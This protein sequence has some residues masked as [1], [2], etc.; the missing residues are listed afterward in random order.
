MFHSARLKLTGWYLLIIMLVSVFFSLLLFQ[1][2][3]TELDRGFR[4]AE[5]RLY[6]EEMGMHLP[7][8]FSMKRDDLQPD[9]QNLTPKFLLIED[10]KE[11]RQSILIRLFL[12]NGVILVVSAIASYAMAGK[13]L[14]PLEKALEDQKRFVADASH[15]LRTPLTALKT[16]IEVALRDKRFSL[17]KARSVLSESLKDIDQLSHLSTKLLQLSKLQQGVKLQLRS[18]D[19]KKLVQESIKTIAPLAKAKQIIVTSKLESGTILAETEQVKEMILIILDNAIK[20][21]AKR[22]RVE[23]VLKSQKKQMVLAVKDSGVG[24]SQKDLPF[25]FDRFYQV[26]TARGKTNTDGFGLGLSLAE[27]IIKAHHGSIHVQSREGE[28]T[29]FSIKLPRKQG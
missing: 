11:A 19:F 24:I 13:T 18:V 10:L 2:V 15:E 23:I 26:D 5:L 14:A 7:R 28:G 8:Q 25:I 27:Q 29:T 17:T 1:G 4:R 12:V 3:S 9:L 6:A 16:S 21:T 22:G 20:Y